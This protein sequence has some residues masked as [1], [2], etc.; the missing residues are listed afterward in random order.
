MACDESVQENLDEFLERETFALTIMGA[1]GRNRTYR[2]NVGPD[3]RLAFRE[4]LREYLNSTLEEYRTEQV[5]EDRHL[6]NIE[7][8][9]SNLSD[10]HQEILVDGKFRIGAAQKALN[11]YLKYGWAR[12]II[13]EPPH[14]PID[15]IVIAKLEKCPRS[16]ECEICLNTTWTTI[17]TTHEY[18]HFIEKARDTASA[19]Q[20]SLAQWELEVWKEA[21]SQA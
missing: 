8:L 15:S 4:S 2:K 10:R 7:A 9:S 13:R 18:L 20:R 14:C 19:R 3:K 1:M 12:G 6:D 17:R 21:T 11:L 5:G 16:A